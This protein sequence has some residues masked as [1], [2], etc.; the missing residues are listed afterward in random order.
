MRTLIFLSIPVFA[1]SL[2]FCFP[3]C[4][5]A[6]K[7]ENPEEYS[8]LVHESEKQLSNAFKQ[9]NLGNYEEALIFIEKALELDEENAEA[10]TLRGDIY[11]YNTIDYAQ[12]IEN[13]NKAID[14]T[15]NNAILY[16]KRSLI[17]LY[18]KKFDDALKDLNRAVDLDSDNESFKKNQKE[19][20]RVINELR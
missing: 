20:Q 15:P 9:R 14:L 8:I 3:S 7:D 13:Y 6:D 2:L 5:G 19:V 11:T 4:Q 17:R 10:Y 12:A 18:E 1:F 16:D